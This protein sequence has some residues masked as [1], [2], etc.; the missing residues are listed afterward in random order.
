MNCRTHEHRRFERTLRPWGFYSEGHAR[1][2]VGAKPG[3]RDTPVVSRPPHSCDAAG[4]GRGAHVGARGRKDAAPQVQGPQKALLPELRGAARP[5]PRPAR[6]QLAREGDASPRGRGVPR[7]RYPRPP[8]RR[9]RRAPSG[10]RPRSRRTLRPR[11]GRD[12]PLSLSILLSGGKETN[13]DSPSSCERT[14]KSPAP[15]P[16]GAARRDMWC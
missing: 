1:P 16:A 4:N 8:S 10:A 11:I 9:R 6:R 12:Y 13:K 14:G 5:G 2:R 7:S 3:R 15:N